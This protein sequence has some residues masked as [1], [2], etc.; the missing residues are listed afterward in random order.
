MK[1]VFHEEYLQTYTSD[2]AAYP[3]R[4][5]AIIDK[6]SGQVEF[7]T[8]ESADE[9][10]IAAV[11][12]AS[13]IEGVRRRGLYHISA[14]A[15]G[16]A[17]KAAEVGLKEPC[18]AV[19]RPPGH[20]ASANSSWGFCYFNNMA[21]AIMYLMNKQLIRSAY[22]LD[23]DLHYGDGSV[24]ILGGKEGITIYNPES[25]DRLTYLQKVTREMKDCKADIIGVSAGFDNHLKDWGGLLTTEDYHT[26]GQLVREASQRI[27]GGCFGILEGGY[28]HN[29]LGKNTLA[30]I[31]GISGRNYET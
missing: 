23:I 18:F 3:G 5:E 20:H 14:L 29:V 2:P 21:V 8:P 16:G 30:F 12:T 26:I 24:N 25:G 31:N 10:D 7:L 9:A 15:A 19:I 1:V 22:I 13:H 11:H 4:L 27:G 28:N 17:V 6:I